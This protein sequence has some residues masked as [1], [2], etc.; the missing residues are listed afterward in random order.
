MAAARWANITTSMRMLGW[1]AIEGCNTIWRISKTLRVAAEK[2]D[3]TQSLSWGKHQGGE[4][5]QTGQDETVRW[6]TRQK[7]I[8]DARKAIERRRPDL[9]QGWTASW[10]EEHLLQAQAQFL[11]LARWKE[12]D[13]GET[14]DVE[15]EQPALPELRR[16]RV[17]RSK[18]RATPVRRRQRNGE[19][20]NSE[21]AA[22]IARKDRRENLLV[23]AG[24]WDA[25]M[26]LR[27]QIAALTEQIG[28][29][30][31]G[32]ARQPGWG[33]I[34]KSWRDTRDG[35]KAWGAHEAE[36]HIT[37]LLGRLRRE[38]KEVGRRLL[39]Q[40]VKQRLE[41]Y[42][43]Q[44]GWTLGGTKEVEPELSKALLKAR[45][46]AERG[47]PNN[48]AKVKEGL[49][50]LR[51]G[52][53]HQ[54]KRM[55]GLLETIGSK[56]NT[57][58]DRRGAHGDLCG[59]LEHW[60]KEWG[61]LGERRPA[62]A[63]ALH[64]LGLATAGRT[65]MVYG[66]DGFVRKPIRLTEE[67]EARTLLPLEDLLAKEIGGWKREGEKIMKEIA[68][69]C[70]AYP[71]PGRGKG[72][73]SSSEP[74]PKGPFQEVGWQRRE[75]EDIHHTLFEAEV[76]SLN[77]DLKGG[78]SREEVVGKCRNLEARRRLR[79]PEGRAWDL[80]WM[81]GGI[82]R[83]QGDEKVEGRELPTWLD[84]WGTEVLKS[85]R[86]A[87]A[88]VECPGKWYD[89]WRTV[90]EALDSI[91]WDLKTKLETTT[92]VGREVEYLKEC[93]EKW[94]ELLRQG[95]SLYPIWPRHARDA[96]ADSLLTAL[97]LSWTAENGSR[98]RREWWVA[99]KNWKMAAVAAIKRNQRNTREGPRRSSWGGAKHEVLDQV[100]GTVEVNQQGPLPHPQEEEGE[101]VKSKPAG[102]LEQAKQVSWRESE[103]DGTKTAGPG[104]GNRGR[105]M[106]GRNKSWDRGKG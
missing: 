74:D 72:L 93:G 5:N 30:E 25:W 104:E 97:D 48:A 103:E 76:V 7:Q 79:D 45:S 22:A 28:W 44:M 92:Q 17:V 90:E 89:E 12:E 41:E 19:E 29:Q 37:D 36:W 80:A 62:L 85:M 88:S 53:R 96:A 54:W 60:G 21:V 42:L 3:L 47:E 35:T 101:E 66:P 87:H 67:A 32:G 10:E 34:D 100:V 106:E 46:R 75:E 94:V 18:S 4:P 31:E 55:C 13:K 6:K 102:G 63:Q 91:T 2:G 64:T 14:S 95:E 58:L 82:K 70:R 84:E 15:R 8:G 20:A 11:F 27:G 40:A 73:R 86:R 61:A 105:E 9:P 83:D 56:G 98:E 24:K 39:E 57:L 16:P 59:I 50:G 69:G 81:E 52:M 78:P 68:R 51:E 65:E 33:K 23:K 99:T 43:L 26:D 38:P 71:A 77:W 49:A 1:K